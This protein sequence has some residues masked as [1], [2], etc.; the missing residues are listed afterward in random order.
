MKLTD[1]TK[2]IIF[3]GFKIHL[4]DKMDDE[5]YIKLMYRCLTG[6]KLDLNNPKSFNEKLQWLKLHNRNPEYTKMVDKYEVKK[7][8]ADIIGDEYIIPTIG[9]YEKFDDIDF[10]SLPN[11]FVIK[12]THD[13]GGLVICKD[14][15]KLDL[16]EAKK[17]INKCLKKNYYY[18][19]REWPYKDVKP[20]I[21]IE[22]YQEDGDRI[23]PEDYKIYCFDGKPKYIVVFHNRFLKDSMYS[24]SVY[25]TDWNKLDI[26]LD[27]HFAVSDIVEDKPECLDQMLDFARQLS[28]GI[29]QS[30]IDFYIINGKIKFGEIT[31][32]T[33]SGTQKM[34]PESLDREL[35]DLIPLP[36]LK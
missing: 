27:C 3:G 11:Q 18:F 29:P 1:F 15:S 2:Y 13:S 20:R 16:V 25:D 31:F 12:C 30:R 28:E 7:Y 32:Y 9:I 17:K 14:K 22:E 23:V 35:G 10:D 33:A 34:I 21:I 24:E 8:V 4:F 36:N 19:T 6:D 26:S 5:K